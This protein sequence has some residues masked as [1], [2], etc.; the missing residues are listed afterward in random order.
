MTRLSGEAHWGLG[1][2]E[3]V[4]WGITGFTTNFPDV[5]SQRPSYSNIKEKQKN[6]EY[7]KVHQPYQKSTQKRKN[8]VLSVLGFFWPCRRFYFLIKKDAANIKSFC[9]FHPSSRS[10]PGLHIW[11]AENWPVSSTSWGEGMKSGRQKGQPQV[12]LQATVPHLEKAAKFTSRCVLL[13]GPVV[14]GTCGTTRIK[15]PRLPCHP[16]LLRK[17]RKWFFFYGANALQMVECCKHKNAGGKK[18]KRSIQI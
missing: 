9:D 14:C 5:T 12:T 4:V 18:K 1:G 3:V 15:Q 7:L 8:T 2:R 16:L 6:G 11:N 10:S 13:I 17:W